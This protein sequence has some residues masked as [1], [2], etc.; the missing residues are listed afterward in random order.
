VNSASCV[1]K[2]HEYT[3]QH[4][5]HNLWRFC[6][7]CLGPR[8]KCTW[9]SQS[10]RARAQD[11]GVPSDGQPPEPTLA[12]WQAS[13]D[14]ASLDRASLD[15]AQP[16]ARSQARDVAR[17]AYEACSLTP[18]TNV[19]SPGAGLWAQLE[20]A[21]ERTAEDMEAQ[22][23]ANCLYACDK[24]QH[25]LGDAA[26]GAML[27]GV[28]KTAGDMAGQQ[29][30]TT[31][32]SLAELSMA[33][34]KPLDSEV[35]DSLL[36]A[37][38]REVE[39]MHGQAVSN[40]VWALAVLNIPVEGEVRAALTAAVV[41]TSGSMR[42][43][44][45]ADVLWAFATFHQPVEGEL[46]EV[47]VAA[48]MERVGDMTEPEVARALLALAMLA[49]LLTGAQHRALLVAA[50]R[51]CH[52]MSA[53]HIANTIWALA[54]L[55]VPVEGDADDDLFAA[56]ARVSKAMRPQAVANTLF[57]LSKFGTSMT[58]D[59]LTALLSDAVRIAEHITTMN[60][61]VI[62]HA[63]AKLRTKPDEQ[64]RQRVIAALDGGESLGPGEAR[65]ACARSACCRRSRNSSG[66]CLTS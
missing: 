24:F 13:L 25:K 64:T 58:N 34:S 61:T 42:A 45:V 36:A 33:D 47:L 29:V 12:E 26:R 22:H 43:A 20:Q 32:C 55:N 60:A 3:L 6:R 49:E 48:A 44:E 52:Q 18:D 1:L 37:A 62:L 16:D 15:R 66:L 19:I 65:S 9:Q 17:I 39:A 8:S 40:T 54:K 7:S 38:G 59:R 2:H 50:L 57:A 56:A 46:R 53:Q 51:V 23:L 5:K 41:R 14:R 31:L 28:L 63:M 4:S 35:G 30:P 27:A 11:S 21:F 10:C